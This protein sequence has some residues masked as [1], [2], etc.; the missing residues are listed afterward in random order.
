MFTIDYL[1][2]QKQVND[3]SLHA[4]LF[5]VSHLNH[6][7]Q[8]YGSWAFTQLFAIKD[9]QSSA[10][11]LSDFEAHESQYYTYLFQ[12]IALYRRG[13]Q[14]Q[15]LPEK[16][17]IDHTDIEEKGIF[18]M[19]RPYLNEIWGSGYFIFAW[20]QKK[21]FDQRLFQQC[22]SFEEAEA[23]VQK[24]F[25]EKDKYAFIIARLLRASFWHTHM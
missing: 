25:S 19:R 5:F 3:V 20:N 16:E 1:G 24:Q 4:S 12:R 13:K 11:L 23:I 17:W 18:F 22:A 15:T 8:D 9:Y 21:E 14:I 7:K 10:T 2:N 6:P